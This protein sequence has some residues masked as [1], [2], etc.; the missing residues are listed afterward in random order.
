M[1]RVK[2]PI[3]NFDAKNN[4]ENNFSLIVK[5]HKNYNDMCV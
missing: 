3:L 2:Y 1:M 4:F 5:Y